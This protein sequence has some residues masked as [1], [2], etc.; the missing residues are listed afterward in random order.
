[1]SLDGPA[2]DGDRGR[3][4][5]ALLLAD[6]EDQE[7]LDEL[8][9]LVEDFLPW[10]AADQTDVETPVRDCIALLDGAGCDV[11]R[12]AIERLTVTLA[13]VLDPALGKPA[14]SDV[15]VPTRPAP[16][17][18]GQ[19]LGSPSASPARDAPPSASLADDPELVREFIDSSREHLDEADACLL[20]L[21]QDD[22]DT[23]AVDAVFRSFHTIKGMAGFLALQAVEEAAHEAEDTLDAVRKGTLALDQGV[24]DAQ[25]A[26]V[27][28]LREL[29]GQI[30]VPGA[31]GAAAAEVVAPAAMGEAQAHDNATRTPQTERVQGSARQRTAHPATPVAARGTVHVDEERLDRLLETIGELVI[32]EASVSR[33]VAALDGAAEAASAD[34][35]R[36]DKISRQLQEMATSMRMVAFRT[37]MRRMARLVRD[38]AH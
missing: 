31:A 1:M 34:L 28:L 4:A 2:A 30:V 15:A 9:A 38:L 6:P 3:L 24:M 18:A 7:S 10:L 27:D 32:A 11:A 36:L 29:V 37:T 12:D 20:R 13:P 17:A 16:E 5:E 22:K 14:G 21:E 33:S 35:G 26:A 8:R 25:F 23:E 19:G